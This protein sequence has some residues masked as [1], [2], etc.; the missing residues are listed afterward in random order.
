MQ[1]ASIFILL[2][3]CISTV[4][5]AANVTVH[6]KSTANNYDGWGLHIW[7]GEEMVNGKEVGARTDFRL[8]KG[9]TP[10]TPLMPSKFD[11]FGVA[12]TIPVRNDAKQFSYTL[13]NGASHHMGVEE[14]K[15]IKSKHGLNIWIVEKDPK[16]YT[17]LPAKYSN[18]AS[19]TKKATTTT[20]AS[21]VLPPPV[22][23][24]PKA[25]TTAT[26][27]ATKTVAKPKPKPK[28]VAKSTTSPE[29]KRTLAVLKD[30]LNKK[31][32]TISKLQSALNDT[33]KINQRLQN[34]L[35][36]KLIDYQ[37]LLQ[38]N[39]KVS[40][41]NRT[42]T[43]TNQSLYSQV[44]QAGSSNAEQKLIERNQQLETQLAGLNEQM[45][46]LQKT[47]TENN[48]DVGQQKQLQEQFSQLQTQRDELREQNNKLSAHIVELVQ[49]AESSGQP[50]QSGIAWWLFGAVVA[51]LVVLIGLV[52]VATSKRYKD[53]QFDM[54]DA[55][56]RKEEEIK[57]EKIYAAAANEKLRKVLHGEAQQRSWA[58][59]PDGLPEN[60]KK[61]TA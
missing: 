54:E 44:E 15:W 26:V 53:L 52:F 5:T 24:A 16:I 47:I 38:L 49:R 23:K 10:D 9:T 59:L 60:L 34:D 48:V 8:R 50:Q 18:T 12:F 45:L 25:A 61:D 30:D 57:T 6:Y 19:T 43:A 13:T 3:W 51:V 41:E 11:D 4:A 40:N 39:D 56:K 20:K 21:A 17:S 55:I 28:A 14:W 46:G 37:A 29:M 27:A 36:S 42:L 22:P 7:A 1:R 32:R 33:Q 31:N 35:N 2:F 58:P